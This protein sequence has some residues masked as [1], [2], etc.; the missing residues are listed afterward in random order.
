MDPD[1]LEFS[2]EAGRELRAAALELTLDG[3]CF[4]DPKILA[5][6]EDTY[7]AA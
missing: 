4:T 6:K 3:L 5:R 1:S 7:V 2:E